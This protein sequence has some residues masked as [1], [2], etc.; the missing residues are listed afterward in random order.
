MATIWSA[1]DFKRCR[2]DNKFVEIPFESV[3]NDGSLEM[4]EKGNMIDDSVSQDLLNKCSDT[5]ANGS[6]VKA[7]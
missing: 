6:R 1:Q 4:N 5:V 7:A 2:F 3:V